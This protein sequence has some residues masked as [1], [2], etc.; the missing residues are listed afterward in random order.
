MPELQQIILYVRKNRF[1]VPIYLLNMEAHF[2][3]IM[4]GLKN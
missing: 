1:I 2:D 4:Q 3:W